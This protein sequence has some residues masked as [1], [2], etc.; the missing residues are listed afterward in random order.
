MP[1]SSKR[2]RMSL[3]AIKIFRPFSSVGLIW[4]LMGCS[5]LNDSSLNLLDFWPSRA[6][7]AYSRGVDYYRQGLYQSAVKELETVPTDH[8]RYKRAQSYLAKATH[9]VTEA[10]HHVNAALQYR[11]EGELFKAKKEFEDALEVYPKHRRVW[12][13]LEALDLDIEATVNFYYEKGQDEFDQKEY[14]S[15]RIAFLEAL[16]A[17]PDESQ[18]L[19]E[20]SKTNEIL[21]KIYSKEGSLLFEKGN[22]DDA[23]ERLEKAYDIDSGDP[24]VIKQL[25]TAYNLR[26]LKYYREEKL[27]LAVVDLKRSLEIKPDQEEI[28]NQR[29]Q[30]QKRL[31]LLEK[32]RP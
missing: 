24:V 3:T 2:L 14:E 7:D 18:V 21:V 19:F 20:L 13:L 10:T 5:L 29:Q 26:A 23:V 15:A 32:I 27:S 8:P 28:Q 31:G 11:K 12:M 1:D 4:L 6:I 16:K 17:D 22:F 25:T 30:I 9:R